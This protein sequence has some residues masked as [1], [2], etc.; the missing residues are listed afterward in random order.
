MDTD[1]GARWSLQ[2]NGD[3]V[4]AI[5]ALSVVVVTSS[6]NG[7]YFSTSWGWLTMA[8]L[9][10]AA[11]GLL[12][13]PSIQLARL[14]T[15]FLGGMTAFVIWVGLSAFWSVSVPSSVREVERD[16]VY[17]AL[18]LA[19]AVFGRYLTTNGLAIGV[20]AGV[21]AVAAYALA[22]RLFPTHF[23]APDPAFDYR[24]SVPLGYWNALGA[25]SAL[26]LILVVGVAAQSTS[27]A[28]RMSAGAAAC[29]VVPTM[30]F[31]FSRGA[32]I[33]AAVGLLTM[34]V[35]DSRRVA[36]AL[37]AAAV[38]VPA[39]ILVWLGLNST[40]LTDM[41]ATTAEAAASGQRYAVVVV[42]L[43][44]ISAVLV[45][46]AHLACGR[47]DPG[48]RAE[49]LI[50]VGALVLFVG[51]FAGALIALGG[52]KHAVDRGW[53]AFS[54]G[55]KPSSTSLT[56]R[57]RTVSSNG[58]VENWRV[59]LVGFRER[60]ALGS[61]AG[62][63]EQLWYRERRN[64]LAMRDAHSLYLEV[65]AE[66]GPVG[67]LL[68]LGTMSVPLVGFVRSRDVRCVPAS[69]GVFVAFAF[70]AGIDWDWEV[71]GLTTTAI[72][73]GTVGL[74]DTRSLERPLVLA[75]RWRIASAAIALGVL[76]FAFF[77]FVGNSDVAASRRALADGEPSTAIVRAKRA[78]RTLRWSIEPWLA[79][80]E[81]QRAYRD[82]SGA[83]ASFERATSMDPGNWRA[84]Q[85]LASASSGAGRRRALTRAL[86][87]NPRGA[88]GTSD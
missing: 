11:T 39:I 7:S 44:C 81:A 40:A 20:F 28:L 34:A 70:H 12:F 24:L 43:A 52:P 51:L 48:R 59:A 87:L 66:V 37:A 62:T 82:L 79:R 45:E 42:G 67:L 41:D 76:A 77:S 74:I 54:G 15:L 72:V 46:G 33:A 5:V 58:R 36:L 53:S 27:R 2:S 84:W 57:F 88:P 47:L 83:R 38:I 69:A 3:I 73:A 32:W 64:D 16:V 26:G 1:A 50:G 85:A 30:L 4:S 23:A 14:Q 78:S 35:L 9:G 18:A 65:L 61:G 60:P 8:L 13:M 6:H 71:V 29:V 63:Y 17:V 68:L 21:S 22:T 31:T 55:Y 86:L 25:F 10:L 49:R 80:G 75:V 19:L 56:D